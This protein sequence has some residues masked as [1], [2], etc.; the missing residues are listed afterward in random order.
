[1]PP[2]E[3]GQKKEVVMA[4]ETEKKVSA[5]KT[6]PDQEKTRDLRHKL[7]QPITVIMSC[8][9]LIKLRNP[10]LPKD[11]GELLDMMTEA[12]EEIRDIIG[13]IVEDGN[14]GSIQTGDSAGSTQ[15]S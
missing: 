8:T 5:G 11:D 1:M 12:A 3:P 4:E 2:P 7:G 10:G 14:P 15:K 13:E 6:G 9:E